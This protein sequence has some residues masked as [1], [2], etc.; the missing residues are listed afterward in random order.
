MKNEWFEIEYLDAYQMRLLIL[1]DCT[2][3][4]IYHF[5]QIS[6][7]K[8]KLYPIEN[9]YKKNERCVIEFPM[10]EITHKV[11]QPIDIVYMDDILCIVN[12]PPFLLVHPDGTNRDTL[13]ERLNNYLYENG[14]PHFAQALHRID[15]E[16][17]GIVLFCINPFFQALLDTMFQ[18]HDLIKE[19][20]CIV[21]KPFPFPSH[22]INQ[23][24]S[25]NRHDAKKMIVH[26]K[27]KEAISYVKRINDKHLRVRIETGRKHQIRVHLSNM[28]YP[29]VNDPLYGHVSDSR[30]LLLQN[31]RII[32]KHP[33]TNEKVDIQLELDKRFY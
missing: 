22:T 19:Y 21:E 17:S 32:F 10:E 24:I 2:K 30:G 14:Y 1:D 11:N 20:E 13:Q 27:G 3:Q 33:L 28:G 31:R 18:S 29:I 7:S 8:Q 15:V 6:K 9:S 23:P 12:K 16:T 25:R 4:D 26:P 5:F